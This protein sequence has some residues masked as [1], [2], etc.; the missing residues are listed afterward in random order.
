[1]GHYPWT[2]RFAIVQQGIKMRAIVKKNIAFL[3]KTCQFGFY[4]KD[5]FHDYQKNQIH[6]VYDFYCNSKFRFDCELQ[7]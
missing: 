3:K 1:M 5:G 6:F 2:R 7:F 4:A